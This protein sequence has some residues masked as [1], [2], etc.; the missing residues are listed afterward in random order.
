[1]KFKET[2]LKN[3]KMHVLVYINPLYVCVCVCVCVCFCSGGLYPLKTCSICSY[4]FCYVVFHE[5]HN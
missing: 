1:M 4:T 5:S 2:E 3:S